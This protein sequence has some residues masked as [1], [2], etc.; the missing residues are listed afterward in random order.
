MAKHSVKD[1]LQLFK[2]AFLL[3]KDHHPIKF[4]SAIAY[5]AL[6]G[7]PSIFLIIVAVLR[8]FFEKA[9][10]LAELE[11][12][13]N[14]VVGKEGGQIL[15]TITDRFYEQA[16]Q[17]TWTL[18]FY[19]VS[20][21]W[22]ST[23][24]YR[25]FQNSLNELWQIKPAYE[26]YWRKLWVE[27]GFTLLLVIVTGLLFFASV[28]FEYALNLTVSTLGGNPDFESGFWAILVNILTI[29]LVFVWFAFLYKVLPA[30]KIDWEPTLV[31]AAVNTILFVAGVWIL[32]FLVIER[33][34]ED[35]YAYVAPIIQVAL[36]VFY[37]SLIFLY[38]ASFTKVYAHLKSKEIQ[39]AGYAYKYRI[40]KDEAAD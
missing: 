20:T 2:D 12:Q 38:G 39:P 37:N 7:L 23:Q 10:I 33:D 34:L 40:A 11:E 5:F 1:Y 14:E 29:L 3:F 30:V 24:L 26:S 6:F 22:L 36:W 18:L 28:L 8:S 13:L 21:V 15:V 25:L 17:N 19:T 4:A 16:S 27:R 35:L 9:E 32:W 31:G